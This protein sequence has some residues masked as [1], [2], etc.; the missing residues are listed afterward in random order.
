M[1]SRTLKKTRHYI[2]YALLILACRIVRKMSLAAALR[3]ANAL[4]DATF[5]ILRIRRCVTEE[6]LR[7]A[8]PE[9]RPGEIEEIAR[10]AYRHAARTG[11]ELIRGPAEGKEGLLGRVRFVRR[12]L[13]DE[14][15]EAGRGAVLLTGHFG[16][17]ELFGAALVHAGYPVSFVVREQNN[18]MTDRVINGIRTQTGAEVIPLGMAIR[19]V[20]RNLRA[21]KFVALVADQD[22]GRRGVFVEFFGRPSSTAAGPAAL[23]I[24]TGAPVLF[25]YAVRE[26]RGRHVLYAESIPVPAGLTEEETVRTVLQDYSDQLER[27]IREHPDHWFWMHKRWK[28]RIPEQAG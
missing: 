11:I 25:G 20:I 8:F 17:W 12:E 15:L 9:K 3:T 21:N 10:S 26:A 5:R 27:R 22:A 1:K 14:A 28:T 7:A 16:N 4:G 23:A 18:R 2:E 19:G 24:K 6:N 13:L